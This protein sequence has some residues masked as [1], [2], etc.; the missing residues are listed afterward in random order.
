MLQSGPTQTHLFGDNTSG[1]NSYRHKRPVNIELTVRSAVLLHG[2]P[3]NQSII[4]VKINHHKPTSCRNALATVYQRL[5]TLNGSHSK[6]PQWIPLK[7]APLKGSPIAT[8]LLIYIEIQIPPK[9]DRANPYRIIWR[10]VVQRAQI[11]SLKKIKSTE[12]SH[13]LRI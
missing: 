10:S 5:S 11:H 8:P 3:S 4:I 2:R 13:F 1:R 12:A 9:V 7:E 6:K